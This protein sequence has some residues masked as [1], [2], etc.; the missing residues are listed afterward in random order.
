M[1]VEYAKNVVGIEDAAHAEVDSG[2]VAVIVPLACSLVGESRAVRT[3]RGTKA[4]AICGAESMIGYHFCR[5][6]LSTEMVPLLEAAGL[7]FSGHGDDGTIEI[8]EL[9]QHPFL[10][11]TLFQPQVGPDDAPLHPL[12]VAFA[13]A[14]VTHSLRR[15]V[16]SRPH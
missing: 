4:G 10:L 3:V 15:D 14:V 9:P 6:G 11:A 8:V 12:L 13:D 1:L 16:A 5:Y 2:G 7:V